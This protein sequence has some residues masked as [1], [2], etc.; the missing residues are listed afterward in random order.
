VDNRDWGGLALA[1]FV[2]VIDLWLAWYLGDYVYTGRRGWRR[3]P[4]GTR[5]AI[6]WWHREILRWIARHGG[7][8]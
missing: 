7:K 5:L 2:F 1:A 4:A 3:I 8:Q 6:D